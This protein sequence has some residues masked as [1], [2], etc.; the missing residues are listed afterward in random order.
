M[1]LKVKNVGPIL[2]IFSTEPLFVLK[3]IRPFILFQSAELRVELTVKRKSRFE[4]WLSY[5]ANHP[6][7]CRAPCVLN[8]L[9][10]EEVSNRI[11]IIDHFLLGMAKVV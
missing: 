6:I 7:F 3:I 2:Y 11:S 4:L 10:S 9:I 1:L 5:L 8:F